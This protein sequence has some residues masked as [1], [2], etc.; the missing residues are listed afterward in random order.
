MDMIQKMSF[1]LIHVWFIALSNY[2]AKEGW[3]SLDPLL[4]VFSL[5]YDIKQ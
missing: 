1:Y 2:I 4:I 5:A 3:N